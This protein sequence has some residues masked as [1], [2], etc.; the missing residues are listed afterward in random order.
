MSSFVFHELWSSRRHLSSFGPFSL[1][2]SAQ[3]WHFCFPCCVDILVWSKAELRGS[4]GRDLPCAVMDGSYRRGWEVVDSSSS[5]TAAWFSS[6]AASCT[7]L[8]ICHTL[9]V[10]CR[11]IWLELAADSVMGSW[12][13]YV[14]VVAPRPLLETCCCLFSAHS[15]PWPFA[16]HVLKPTSSLR[17]RFICFF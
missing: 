15:S 14:S 17:S 9:S 11:L 8:I 12:C 2:L 16:V 4:C 5:C 1:A 6:K 3:W 13:T 10:T 7:N